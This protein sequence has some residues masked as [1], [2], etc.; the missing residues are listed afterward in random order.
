MAKRHITVKKEL[1]DV[2]AIKSLSV[3]LK[4]LSIEEIQQMTKVTKLPTTEVE[5]TVSPMA[6]KKKK[7]E[8]DQ[9]VK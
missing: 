7:L 9:K 4:K 8:S 2:I 3:K 5:T 6:M 1:S